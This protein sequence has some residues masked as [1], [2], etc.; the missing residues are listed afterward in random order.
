MSTKPKFF[1]LDAGQSAFLNDLTGNTAGKRLI[2]GCPKAAVGAYRV[3]DCRDSSLFQ[4]ITKKY[5]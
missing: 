1:L 4:S 5:P 2:S 3:R